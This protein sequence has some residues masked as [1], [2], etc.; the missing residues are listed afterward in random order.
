MAIHY[1]CRHCQLNLGKIEATTLSSTQLGFDHLNDLERKEMINYD[2]NGNVHV[3]V[4]C[5]DCQEALDRNP[6]L[7][8]LESFIQ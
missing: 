6:D 8:Q 5:E 4:I 3:K 1:Q 2:G 7:H